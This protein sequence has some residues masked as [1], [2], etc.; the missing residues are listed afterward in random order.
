[1]RG[2]SSLISPPVITYF[3]SHQTTALTGTLV[4]KEFAAQMDQIHSRCQCRPGTNNIDGQCTPSGSKCGKGMVLVNGRCEP[5]SPPGTACLV[6][7]QCI[8][9]S[10]CV[11]VNGQCLE[12]VTLGSR[13]THTQQCLGNSHCIN[14][15]C[16]CPRGSSETK[17]TCSSPECRR[18][19]VII[20]GYFNTKL[21]FEERLKNI[22]SKPT[23][24]HGTNRV[25]SRLI[26]IMANSFMATHSYRN[27][28]LK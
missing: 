4:H 19:Q 2:K 28:M 24:C 13:C 15:F 11:L 16:R 5:L 17:G 3:A 23:D 21:D 1:M 14:G 10:H 7:E 26:T 9:H 22:T 27:F 8:D 6:Q 20:A 12:K 25:K 18:N